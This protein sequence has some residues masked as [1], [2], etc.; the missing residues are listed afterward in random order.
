M[1]KISLGGTPWSLMLQAKQDLETGQDAKSIDNDYTSQLARNTG[2]LRVPLQVDV[3]RGHW[4]L[5]NDATGEHLAL[6]PASL[7]PLIETPAGAW[8]PG[9]A[10]GLP[11]V[12][13]RSEGL[14]QELEDWSRLS[15]DSF[16]T[17]AGVV[18]LPQLSTMRRREYDLR[19][20]FEL[21]ASRERLGDRT[22]IAIGKHTG[23]S[24]RERKKG[25][26]KTTITVELSGAQPDYQISAS[27]TSAMMTYFATGESLMLYGY[28]PKEAQQGGAEEAALIA[29]LVFDSLTGN[30]DDR[31]Q[32]LKFF[33]CGLTVKAGLYP[34][35]R[36][37]GAAP[38]TDRIHGARL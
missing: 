12:F 27:G 9:G 16:T 24:V 28:S 10:P 37:N 34:V 20:A 8:A 29:W 4:L 5:Q 15:G 23:G 18:S 26:F 19:H 35:A 32:A 17:P 33:L 25:G 6:S 36:D 1:H 14:A 11:E 38:F 7:A 31:Q 30:L 13:G 2:Y 3:P 21:R 22:E